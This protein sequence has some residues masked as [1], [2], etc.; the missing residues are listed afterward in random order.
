MIAVKR[1]L[2]HLKARPKSLLD[3][4][5][6]VIG[7]N[8]LDRTDTLCELLESYWSQ[9]NRRPSPGDVPLECRVIHILDEIYGQDEQRSRY[10][11]HPSTLRLRCLLWIYSGALTLDA[12]TLSVCATTMKLLARGGFDNGRREPTLMPRALPLPFPPHLFTPRVVFDTHRDPLAFFSTS[13]PPS[14]ILGV[15]FHL[16]RDSQ[17]ICLTYALDGNL[18]N[19]RLELPSSPVFER[20][21]LA[22]GLLREEWAHSFRHCAE[23]VVS[24]GRANLGAYSA[25]GSARWFQARFIAS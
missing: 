13:K 6:R 4:F 19:R 21:G 24:S 7:W 25:A 14:P 5:A 20:G 10:P 15:L 3:S 12:R 1:D 11:F 9:Y 22:L 17:E 8:T 23:L 16:L 18:E 2:D